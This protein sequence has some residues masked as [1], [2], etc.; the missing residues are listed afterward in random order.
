MLWHYVASKSGFHDSLPVKRCIYLFLSEK[1]DIKN[2]RFLRFGMQVVLMIFLLRVGWGRKIK[3]KL[4][5]Y[6]FF[7]HFIWR[8]IK[9]SSDDNFI[10]ISLDFL[11][12]KYNVVSFE[13][14]CHPDF[15]NGSLLVKCCL[16][17]CDVLKN[18][19]LVL[20]EAV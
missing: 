19:L 16:F 7:S 10:Q 1:T 18:L 9:I 8:S 15:K 5:A 13:Q 3:F 4:S 11:S 17:R 20:Y 2:N 14:E 12:Q 6:D